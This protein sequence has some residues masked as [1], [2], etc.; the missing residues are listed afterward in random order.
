MDLVN[1]SLLRIGAQCPQNPT[2]KQ[3]F[4]QLPLMCPAC[5]VAEL[6]CPDPAWLAEQFAAATENW[7]TA[8]FPP[9]PP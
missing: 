7:V 8:T 3:Q 9:A 5:L 2:S 6:V 1:S 4:A